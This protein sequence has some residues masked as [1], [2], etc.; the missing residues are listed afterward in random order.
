MNTALP[1]HLAE[2]ITAANTQPVRDGGD[3]VLYWMRTAVRAHENPALDVALTIGAQYGR[4][5]FVY[6]ALS[7]RYPHASDRHHRFILE[8]ARDVEAE[9]AARGIGYA[10]HLERPGH[11]G[12]VLHTLARDAAL[13]V[14]ETMPIPPLAD[15]PRALGD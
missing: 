9:C 4:P 8:G 7:E 1:P 2:R 14:T 10:F 5:V 13:I 6:H 11:R 3:F 12:A 15:L